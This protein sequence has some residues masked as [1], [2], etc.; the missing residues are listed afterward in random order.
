LKANGTRH[1]AA[2]FISNALAIRLKN[3]INKFKKTRKAS[4]IKGFRV[5]YLSLAW[6][7]KAVKWL[8]TLQVC[9][10][11]FTPVKSRLC[12]RFQT[13]KPVKSGYSFLK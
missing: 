13:A 7:F 9:N 10:S 11:H 1:F 12:G 6:V 3:K 8:K 2:L 4:K 5:F